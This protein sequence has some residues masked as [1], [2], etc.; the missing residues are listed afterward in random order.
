MGYTW[1]AKPSHATMGNL[2]VQPHV[3]EKRLN[4]MEENRMVRTYQHAS[5]MEEREE[6]FN[7]LGT[8]LASFG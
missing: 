5:L 2:K 6:G 4:Y 3:I 8:K 1:R 7:K